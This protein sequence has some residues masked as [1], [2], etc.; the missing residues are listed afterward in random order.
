MGA[1]VKN[2]RGQVFVAAAVC[3]AAFLALTVV[4]VDIGRLAHTA[5]EVQTVADVAANAGAPALLK[6]SLT[7]AAVDP[8]AEAQF[9][10]GQNTVDGQPAVVT[11]LA[12]LHYDFA[13][14]GFTSGS[15]NAVRATPS[16]TVTNVI[17]GVLGDRQT[18]VTKTATAAM[19]G[20]GAASPSLPMV[21]G[22]CSFNA[23][24]TSLSCGDLPSLIQAPT[25]DNN[26]AWTSLTGSSASASA[27]DD[28]LPAVCGGTLT[29]SLTRRDMG[30]FPNRPTNKPL[31]AG[32]P[33]G[34]THNRPNFT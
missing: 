33:L 25:P 34:C 9:V 26:S 21:I 10:A 22:V 7:G 6:K 29:A 23:F 30:N 31:K 13:S 5:T 11:D 15:P 8:I 20:V 24:Q 3:L 18:T 2:E 17:A 12:L 32:S 1:S 28:Y 16:V 19:S 14:G 27:V 4:A